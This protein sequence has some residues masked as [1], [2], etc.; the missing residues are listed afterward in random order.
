MYNGFIGKTPLKYK[1]N[2]RLMQVIIILQM[3]SQ[4]TA[5]QLSQ[6]PYIHKCSMWRIFVNTTTYVCYGAPIC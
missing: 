3:I 2:V 6:Y 1:I 4:G 5:H